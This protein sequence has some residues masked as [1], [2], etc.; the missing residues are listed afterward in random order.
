MNTCGEISLR[1]LWACRLCHS[2]PIIVITMALANAYEG[3]VC[4]KSFSALPVGAKLTFTA[5]LLGRSY[6]YLMS[7]PRSVKPRDVRQPGS[8]HTVQR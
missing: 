1:H 3:T 4:W 8:G 2:G 5:V 7:Q 6:Y